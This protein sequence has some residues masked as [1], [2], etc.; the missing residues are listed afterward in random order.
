MACAVVVGLAALISVTP[1]LFAGSPASAAP[2]ATDFVVVPTPTDPTR[3]YEELLSVEM[4]GGSSGWAVGQTEIT[5]RTY[6]PA[7]AMHWDGISW[8]SVAVPPYGQDNATL[9]GVAPVSD[10][11]VW[12]T[13]YTTS[14]RGWIYDRPLLIHW[15]G[16]RWRR[17]A[18]PLPPDAHGATLWRS[19]AVS[20]DDVWAVGWYHTRR[21]G[22]SKTLIIHWDGSSWSL[23]S[24]PNVPG[25]LNELR[26]ITATGPDEAW[27]VGFAGNR[28]LI[29]RWDGV[30]WSIESIGGYQQGGLRDVEVSSAGQVFVAG[31][32]YGPR[33]I[34][35]ALVLTPGA[36]G[37]RRM[38]LPNIGSAVLNGVAWASTQAFAVGGAHQGTF[39]LKWTGARWVRLSVENAAQYPDLNG[40]GASLDGTVSAVGLQTVGKSRSIAE[41]LCT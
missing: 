10:N 9:E 24:S 19:E 6:D 23:V 21:Q 4:L 38:P 7:L 13:G 16:T 12:A 31:T 32:Q 26:A 27:A 20:T 2:C 29:E 15:N 40:V 33:D 1:S 8:T 35:H 3:D 36:T 37:W 11:D 39:A 5:G 34:S 30:R 28:M 22:H 41:T 14:F 25:H 18:V 17:F